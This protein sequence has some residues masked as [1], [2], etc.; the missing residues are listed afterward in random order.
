MKIGIMTFWW[1]EDNYGQ[2]LQCYALQKYL[3]NA[4]HDAYLI[5]YDPR[6]DYIK[7][8]LW[9]RIIKAFNPVKLYKFILSKKRKKDDLREKLNNPRGF[10]DFRN[11]HIKQSEKI[12]Y[13]YKELAENPPEADIYIT[14]S[15][16]VWN[17]FDIP[18]NKAINKIKAY[19]LDFGNPSIK[20]IAYAASFGKETLDDDAIQVFAPLLK[21]FDYISVREKTGLDICKQCGIDNVEWV[22]DPTM[23]LD[24]DVYRF[25]YKN[26]PVR[27]HDNSYCFLYFLGNESDF[28]LRS[29]Y[30]WAKRRNLEV[31][32]VTG[33]S[34]H[35]KFDKMYM[36]IPEWIYLLEHSEYVIT[37]SYHCSLFALLFGNKYCVI[38]LKGSDKGMNSRF[39][40]L[41][42]LFRIEKRFIDPDFSVLDSDINWQSVS[43]NIQ[44]AR[45]S[46]KLLDVI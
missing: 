18:I 37:N 21:K 29:I 14:G 42:E 33:N 5:R 16:Q 15:D 8:P 1:S 9:R 22:S 12:Y 10:G 32:Y 39:N 30:D 34:K 25:I 46:C 20:R 11:K 31:I 27:K 23:L 43:I 28:S 45:N 35:D 40:S 7:N 3:R 26:E 36:T 4:G 6:N 24:A 38:P 19:L 17:T 44:N 41:F 13:S 2:I